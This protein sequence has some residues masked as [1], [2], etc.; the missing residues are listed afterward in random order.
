ML[1]PVSWSQ[2]VSNNL[3]VSL[4]KNRP[5]RNHRAGDNNRPKY[6]T[7]KQKFKQKVKPTVFNITKIRNETAN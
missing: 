2:K 1:Q 5:S 7:L 4:S 6:L 3:Q